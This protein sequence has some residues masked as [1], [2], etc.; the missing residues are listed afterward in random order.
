MLLLD[1]LPLWGTIALSVGI[2]AIVMA[3]IWLY[4]VPRIRRTIKDSAHFQPVSTNQ[5]SMSPNGNEKLNLT[6]ESTLAKYASDRRSSIASIEIAMLEAK[7]ADEE[8]TPEVARLFSFLQVLTAVF[9]SFA[10]GGNDVS[11]AIGPLI[12]LWMVYATSNVNQEGEI[13]LWIMLYGG[14]GICAGLW[15][16]GRRV[17][18]TVGED[19]TKVTPSNG[20]SIEIGAAT[21]VLLA[22]KI[23]LPISTTHC[24]VGSIV[25]VGWAKSQKAVDWS[26]FKGIVAAWLLTLPITGGLTAL[27]MAI[28]MKLVDNVH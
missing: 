6:D 14:V 11:N 22:S 1:R 15:L 13:P 8:E 21:T 12:A 28:S 23:G 17:I 10:H 24:K 19:L 7:T 25:F 16:W 20:F 3:F 26:L 2:C 27:I 18:Q 9:G 4:Q 5:V